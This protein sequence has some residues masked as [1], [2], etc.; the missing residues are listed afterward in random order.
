MDVN[1]EYYQELL[2][3]RQENSVD[4][5]YERINEDI[6]NSSII[7]SMFMVFPAM[8]IIGVYVL[9][10]ISSAFGLII[11]ALSAM[12]LIMALRSKLKNYSKIAFIIASVMITLYPFIFV[13]LGIGSFYFA[14]DNGDSL[15]YFMGVGFIAISIFFARPIRHLRNKEYLA[16]LKQQREAK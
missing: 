3:K 16:Y 9:H 6:I 4:Q 12:G 10:F 8:I 5:D 7:A 13:L 14:Y 1:E 2:A 15:Y 11:T